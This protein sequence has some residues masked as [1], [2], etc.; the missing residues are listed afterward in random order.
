[1]IQK[2]IV[3]KLVKVWGVNDPTTAGLQ[4]CSPYRYTRI[5]NPNPVFSTDEVIGKKDE[6][7][8]PTP[9]AMRLTEI[10][11]KVFVIPYELVLVLNL[12]LSI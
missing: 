5:Y 7:L 4:N 10:K 12:V 9:D 1:M 8:L 11:T 6:D 3:E 2:Y